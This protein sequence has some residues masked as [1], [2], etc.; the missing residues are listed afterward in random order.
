MTLRGCEFPANHQ[1]QGAFKAPDLPPRDTD[2]QPR[3]AVTCSSST[4]AL[5]PHGGW[6]SKQRAPTWPAPET[7]L[8]TS[9]GPLPLPAI[10]SSTSPQFCLE[11]S[12]IFRS[13]PF[14]P[15][16]PSSQ[17][18]VSPTTPRTSHL[19]LHVCLQIQPPISPSVFLLS[20]M[21]PSTPA[22]D[23]I[24]SGPLRDFTATLSASLSRNISLLQ[25]HPGLASPSTLPHLHR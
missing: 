15:G 3:T 19:L 8:P 25:P 10:H 16:L 4:Q 23:P 6:R 24:S 9:T 14:P 11:T 20:K 22:L 21:N 12:C 13:S 7:S 18:I 2:G 5:G 1:E 17:K